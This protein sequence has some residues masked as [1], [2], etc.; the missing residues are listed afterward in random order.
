M[1]TLARMCEFGED[2]HVSFDSDFEHL[3]FDLV[4]VV[5]SNADGTVT[6][7]ELVAALRA[8]RRRVE[9]YKSARVSTASAVV[10]PT[11]DPD[12][13]GGDGTFS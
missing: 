9:E 6:A 5:D 8:H 12:A 13:P 2:G 3:L 1:T 7:L 11:Y 10:C 4:S